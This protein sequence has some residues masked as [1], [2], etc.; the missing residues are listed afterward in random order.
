LRVAKALGFQDASTFFKAEEKNQSELVV[1]TAEVPPY[2]RGTKALEVEISVL[3]TR[4]SDEPFIE[5]F[6]DLQERRA[7]LEGL[8]IDVDAL[9][10]VT[11][12]AVAKPPYQAE[13]PRKLLLIFIA[14][15]LGLMIGMFLVFAAEFRSKIYDEHENAGA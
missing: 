15:T 3:E 2:M 1:N 10:A 13:K 9:S 6:R 7:F 12:D 5:G 4:K 14:A 8:S 11:V